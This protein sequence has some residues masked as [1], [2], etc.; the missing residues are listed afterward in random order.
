MPPALLAFPL[1]LTSLPVLGSFVDWLHLSAPL[2]AW[3]FLF[4][5]QTLWTLP[6]WLHLV[7]SLPAMQ[8]T[9]I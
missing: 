8:E 5:R 9:W 3:Q 2:C 1:I 7:K 4:E 6:C